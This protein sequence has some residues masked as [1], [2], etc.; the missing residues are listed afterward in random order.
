M[1]S[2]DMVAIPEVYE[3]TFLPLTVMNQTTTVIVI[4][5]RAGEPAD[6]E[7]LNLYLALAGLAGSTM[8]RIS[9]EQELK[10]PPAKPGRI[11]GREDAA[12]KG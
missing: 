3:V 7:L 6:Q 10:V 2:S 11:G 12:L 9:T 1:A 5:H 8:G 4:A